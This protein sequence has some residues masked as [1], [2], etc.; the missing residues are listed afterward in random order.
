MKD[1]NI[2]LNFMWDDCVDS[3]T[4]TVTVPENVDKNDIMQAMEKEHEYLCRDEDGNDTYGTCG[5]TPGTLL[6][7]VC[8]KNGWQWKNFEF[9][10]DVY[11][12]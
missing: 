8:E 12:N 6:N 10:I 1:V 7:Y 5:R 2:K 11:F 4:F 3:D 9:D